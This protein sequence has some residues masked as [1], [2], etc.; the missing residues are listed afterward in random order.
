MAAALATRGPDDDRAVEGDYYALGFRRLAI[1]ATEFGQQPVSDA[2]ANVTLAFNGE[3]YNYGVLAAELRRT[4]GTSVKSEAEA[5]LALYLSRGSGFIESIDG[6]YAIVVCDGR[7][8]ECHLFRDPFGVKP[9]YYAPVAGG[10]A[11]AAA[12]EVQA[13]FHHPDFSTDWDEVALWERRVLGF[14][15]FDRTSFA[16]VRQVPPG[17]CVTLSASAPPRIGTAPDDPCA[18][19]AS[20]LTVDRLAEDCAAVLRQAVERRISH[21]EYFPVA[22]A[23]SGG[24]DSTIIAALA[25]NHARERVVAV[26]IGGAA[27]EEDARIADRLAKSLSLSGTF[28]EVSAD[29]LC[30][31]YPRIVLSGGAQ[32]PAYAAYCL[33]GAV[34]RRCA[35]AKVALCGEGADELFLGYWMHVRAGGFVDRAME[36]LASVPAESI[37]QSPLLRLVAG[38]RS[39]H[40]ERIQ[41][42][43]NAVL[44]T[45]QLVNRHLIPFDHGMM[46]HGIECRVPFLD[47]DV[48][49]FISSVPEP[50]RTVGDTSKVLLRL[51]AS[52][53]L[54]PLGDDLRRLVLGRRPSPLPAALGAARAALRRRIAG[55]L[56]ACDRERSRLARFS[57]GLEDLFWLGA[58]E[59]IFLRH[60]ACADGMELSG[61]ETEILDAVSH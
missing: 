39:G 37:D 26:T 35:G 58:V 38:W 16:S 46:A 23:L 18:P 50:A 43:L 48:T 13:F 59:T 40:R 55:L 53:L 21:S 52:D 54:R 4:R 10:R 28:D 33:G 44:R 9:L 3:I 6:D 15:A 1:V 24:I 14:S 25:G 47:R 45:H 49:G 42:E 5:L 29:F 60:R 2:A 61:M 12:S 11:W 34:R 20:D 30:D 36:A 41:A 19:R 27:D 31:H 17:A 32:G 22:V 7:T 8:R 56:S 51:V 57:T